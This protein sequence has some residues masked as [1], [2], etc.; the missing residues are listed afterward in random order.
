MNNTACGDH[1]VLA[2][3]LRDMDAEIVALEGKLS[4]AR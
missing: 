4:K 1:A 3:T 2:K